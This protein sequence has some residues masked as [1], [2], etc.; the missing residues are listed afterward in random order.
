MLPDLQPI[1]NR[2][3][4][5]DFLLPPDN[6][7]QLVP[8]GEFEH[9]GS[10]LTQVLDRV[11]VETMA[12]QFVNGGERLIDFDH[13]SLNKNKRTTA[14]GWLQ[15]VQARADGLW[16]RIRWSKAGGDAV[17]GGDYKY[18]SPV[19]LPSE[20]ESLGN[21]RVRPLRLDSAGLT[22]RPNLTVAAFANRADEPVSPIGASTSWNDL[23]RK[24]Q[25]ERKIRF[26][27]AWDLNKMTNPQ[28]FQDYLTES[29]AKS[30]I[31]NRSKDDPVPSQTTT[32][33]DP[34]GHWENMVNGI[35]AKEGV[36]FEAAYEKAK[37]RDPRAFVQYE[38]ECNRQMRE[39]DR[40]QL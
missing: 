27:A 14:A 33:C 29:H 26:E 12:K 25:V 7:I 35:K 9:A 3:A 15:N 10:G 5:G 1:A 21:S 17:R 36:S 30:P 2:G 38:Q 18:I 8:L 28:V 40:H 31:P 6:W 24:T 19:F 39:R 13:E 34:V 16:G 22:N 23:V 32:G 4:D 37:V 11:A 20:C